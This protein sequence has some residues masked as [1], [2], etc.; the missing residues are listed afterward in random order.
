MELTMKHKIFAL[1]TCL[2]TTAPLGARFCLF[3][4]DAAE[5]PPLPE[6]VSS[7]GAA[8]EGGWIYE[9]GGHLS[10]THNYS[11][12][13][14]VGSFRRLNASQPQRWEA[15]PGGP[16]LQGLALVSAHGKIY[17]LGGMAPY[18]APGEPTDNR[19]TASCAVFDPAS[20]AWSPLP[21][22]PGAR[23]SHDAA[24]VGNK[25]VVVGGWKMNGKDKESDWYGTAVILDLE[26]KPLEWKEFK[27]PFQRRALNAATLDGKLYVVGGIN[28]EDEIELKV[29]IYEPARDDWT[30]GPP[31]PGPNRNGFSPAACTAGGRLYVSTADGKISRLT[32]D[33]KAWEQVGQLK[34]PRIVH[35]MVALTDHAI[36]T[37]GGASKGDNIALTEV[38]RP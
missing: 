37:I 9:Y 38:W 33:G 5:F 32:Q 19:S 1:L 7:F 2:L 34:Q 6:G 13:A 28:D 14:V 27:Q 8:S 31:L 4:P 23:S 16:K 29:D 11:T 18:N 10:K 15:L 24:V 26:S 35:R 21:D 25:I 3:M 20:N 17:R 30:L 12:E 36:V 22:L